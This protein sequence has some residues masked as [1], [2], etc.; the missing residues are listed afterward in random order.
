MREGLSDSLKNARGS[1]LPKQF[2][3][4]VALYVA[5]L[6]LYLLTSSGYIGGDRYFRY[7]AAVGIVEHG[8]PALLANTLGAAITGKDGWHYSFYGIGQMLLFVPFVLVSKLVKLNA[9]YDLIILPKQ[10]VTHPK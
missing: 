8:S 7:L 4:G 5:F 9:Q 3:L 1:P 6:Y 10:P 2:V